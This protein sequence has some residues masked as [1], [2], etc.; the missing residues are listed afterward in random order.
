MSDMQKGL[1]SA[2]KE[3]FTACLEPQQEH[4]LLLQNQALQG[5][6]NH[7]H[8]QLK[9]KQQPYRRKYTKPSVPSKSKATTKVNVFQQSSIGS[10]RKSSVFDTQ[11][12]STSMGGSRSKYK[13][14]RV[15][16]QSVFV[17]ES[18]YRIINQGMPSNRL[19]STYDTKFNS[20]DM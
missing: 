6:S 14:S 1:I 20:G 4:Q 13:R 8:Q 9:D 10:T 2:T 18:E 16:G 19:V 11:E 17:V 7:N 12:A 3:V 15:V 5:E